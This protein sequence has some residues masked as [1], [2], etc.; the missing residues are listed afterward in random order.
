MERNEIDELVKRIDRLVDEGKPVTESADS[1]GIG[2]ST[3]DAA[4]QFSVNKYADD[5]P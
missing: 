3:Y 2:T 4:Q 5:T 1:V